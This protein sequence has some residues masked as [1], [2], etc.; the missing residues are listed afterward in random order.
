MFA[1][2][3][4]R[5]IIIG[6]L[7]V[8]TGL[9]IGSTTSIHPTNP[10]NAVVKD[11]QELPYIPGSSFK[12][13]LRAHLERILQAVG[14][15]EYKSC[16]IT[17]GIGECISVDETLQRQLDLRK[18]SL[19]DAPDRDMQITQFIE[20]NSCSTCKL[21]GSPLLASKVLVRDLLVDETTW[22]NHYE[23]RDG[24]AIDRDKE[25]VRD[26]GKFD[27]EAVPPG[28]A[29]SCEIIVEN[30]KTEDAEL[31]LLFIGLIEFEH[32]RLAIGGGRSRGLG[33]VKLQ[34]EKIERIT[35]QNLLTYLQTGKG[36]PAENASAFA[37]KQIKAFIKKLEGKKGGG[38]A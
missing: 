4:N 36:T 17:S 6:K 12:G 2:F 21:F 26:G 38:N 32:E 31:G 25:V 34:L 10:D 13:V 29:F 1:A 20:E 8:R 18:E 35:H 14:N 3:N 24:V 33:K 9:H 7:T 30:S 15:S 16:L 37:Q 28:T 23:V 5:T 11:A 19:G 22:F 27:Y